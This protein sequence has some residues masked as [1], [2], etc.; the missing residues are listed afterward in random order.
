MILWLS[1]II[2]Y[3]LDKL[4]LFFEKMNYLHST[5]YNKIIV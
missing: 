1:I 4:N 5:L 3:L 2:R